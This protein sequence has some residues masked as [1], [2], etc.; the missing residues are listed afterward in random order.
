MDME[1]ML[2]GGETFD[3][4]SHLYRGRVR[5]TKTHG[6]EFMILGHHKCQSVQTECLVH[7]LPLPGARAHEGAVRARWRKRL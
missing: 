7:L 4:S 3:F 2:T 1:P 5:L 6:S